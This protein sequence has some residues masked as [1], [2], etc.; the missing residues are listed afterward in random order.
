MRRGRNAKIVATLGPASASPEMIAEL[1]RAGADAFRLNF[2]HGTH[3][4]HRAVYGHIRAL[5]KDTGAP[6]AVL[7]DLI[8]D[9]RGVELWVD[10]LDDVL[11]AASVTG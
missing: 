8:E 5:E 1:Y 10:I 7:A 6:I 4:D 2:S 9:P 11:A 3:D